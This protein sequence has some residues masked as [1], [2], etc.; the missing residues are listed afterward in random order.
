[1]HSGGR[2]SAPSQE[3]DTKANRQKKSAKRM[4]TTLSMYQLTEAEG[5]GDWCAVELVSS[6]YTTVQRCVNSQPQNG[7][8][9]DDLPCTFLPFS[10]LVLHGSN[11]VGNPEEENNGY[12]VFK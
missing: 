4:I 12:V 1:M 6:V 10:L 7:K 5:E 3:V 2:N 9:R 8:N 11:H